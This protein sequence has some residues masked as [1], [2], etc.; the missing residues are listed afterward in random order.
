MAHIRQ[1]R[2]FA[3]LGDLYEHERWAETMIGRIIAPVVRQSEDS[4]DWYWFTRYVTEADEAAGDCNLA[5]IPANFMHRETG[6]YQSMRFRY[7]V[8]DE[9]QADFEERCRALIGD[10]ACA[11]SGFLDYQI[12]DDLGGT[13]HVEEPRTQERRERRAQ[14]VAE[15]YYSVAKLIL[16][17]LKGPDPDGRYHLPHHEPFTGETPFQAFHHIYC[18]AT[19]VPL[20]VRLIQQVPGDPTRPPR[21]EEV[22]HRVRF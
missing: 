16:D 15:H 8:Q 14:L 6:Y 11:I 20:F 9:A 3:P 10:A 22:S 4:L 13:R 19:D 21:L 17:A 5:A 18:N 12:L 1:V 7:S 2:I